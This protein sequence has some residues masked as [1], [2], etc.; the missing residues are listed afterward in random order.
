MNFRYILS[1]ES[2]NVII[3]NRITEQVLFKEEQS[4]VKQ[5]TIIENSSKFI[6]ISRPNNP[7]GEESVRTTATLVVRSIPGKYWN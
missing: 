3:W 1:T 2:G 4:N 6:T 5:L 7:A